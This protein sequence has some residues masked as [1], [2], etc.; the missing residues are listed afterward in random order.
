MKASKVL[1]FNLFVPLMAIVPL[2][3][4]A[5]IAAESIASPAPSSTISATQRR[6]QIFFPQSP[7]SM[8]D[9]TKVVPVWRSTDRT[10]LAQFAVEQLVAGPTRAEQQRGLQPAL[11]LKGASNCGRDFTISLDRGT[12]KLQFCRQ[13]VSNGIGDDARTQ[14]AVRTTLK[15]FSTVRNVVILNP[16]GSCFGDQSGTNRCFTAL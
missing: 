1:L 14:S 10:G 16:D 12:A 5:T 6:V 15:Q 13:V 2:A 3:I 4:P 7:D 9:F 8:N 11:R